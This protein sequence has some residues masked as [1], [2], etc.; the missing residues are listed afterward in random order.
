MRKKTACLMAVLLVMVPAF[1]FA[2]NTSATVSPI[3]EIKALNSMPGS[4]SLLQ[5]SGGKC[6][7]TCDDGSGFSQRCW[8]TCDDEGSSGGGGGAGSFLDFENDPGL[9]WLQ[10]GVILVTLGL[11]A[12]AFSPLFH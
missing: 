9:A 11:C 7:K 4:A 5:L 8:Q 1:L 6:W 12:F 3:D 10:V 2:Q